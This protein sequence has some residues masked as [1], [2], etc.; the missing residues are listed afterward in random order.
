MRDIQQVLERWGAWSASGNDSIDY[1]PIAA[2]FRGLLPASRKSRISCCDDDGLMISSA[3]NCLKKNDAYLCQLLEWHYIQ[4]I[5]V[6]AMGSKLGVSHTQVLKRLQAAEGFIEGCLCMLDVQLQ[7]DR[8]V[9]D[10]NIYE[11]AS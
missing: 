5:P 4:N 11:C 6:R 2:G 7:M 1:S 10:E 8:Y 3:I 9:R